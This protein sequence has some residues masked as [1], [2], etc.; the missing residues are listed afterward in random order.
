M[1]NLCDMADIG[2]HRRKGRAPKE[3]DVCSLIL[4]HEVKSRMTV[5][6]ANAWME[7]YQI[8]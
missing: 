7:S 8:L 5:R 2:D 1:S 6:N 4:G 3:W